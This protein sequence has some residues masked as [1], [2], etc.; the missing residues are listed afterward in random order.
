MAKKKKVLDPSE[1]IKTIP[2]DQLN[3]NHKEDFEALLAKAITIPIKIIK[4]P[5]K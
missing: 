5:K 4:K 3:P 2:Q 1:Y